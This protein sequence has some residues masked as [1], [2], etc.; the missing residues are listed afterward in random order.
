MSSL[1]R[2]LGFYLDSLWKEGERL[3]KIKVLSLSLEILKGWR[4][5]TLSYFYA[6][7]AC[8][9]FTAS[10]FS[11]LIYNLNYFNETGQ[12]VWDI[13]N[14]ITFIVGGL[15]LIFLVWNLDE[16]RWLEAFKIQQ[17]LISLS[18]QKKKSL[19]ESSEKTW[20]E[21]RIAKLIEN[22][23]DEKLQKLVDE[24]MKSYQG[25]LIKDEKEAKPQVYGHA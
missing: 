12:M 2:F 15:A 23:L 11:A 5:I 24:R 21:E 10:C 14:M 9:L 18:M 22:S 13:F 3:T 17:Q 4:Y 6:F 16:K 19:S 7:I 8:I 1:E 20:D 25:Q